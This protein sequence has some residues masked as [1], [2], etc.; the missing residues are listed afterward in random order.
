MHVRLQRIVVSV[1]AV[2]VS[3]T[4]T[5]ATAATATAAT[6]TAATAAQVTESSTVTD[7]RLDRLMRGSTADLLGNSF[8]VLKFVAEPVVPA[9]WGGSFYLYD[10]SRNAIAGGFITAGDIKKVTVTDWRQVQFTPPAAG[11]IEVRYGN[12][13]TPGSGALV[14]QVTVL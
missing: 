3:L 1:L 12:V 4:G 8:T 14:G 11:S 5:V 7:L 2:G 6:A 10:R 13:Q 9:M